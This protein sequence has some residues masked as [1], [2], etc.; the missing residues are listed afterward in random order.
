MS[1]ANIGGKIAE[2]IEKAFFKVF[3]HQPFA[4]KP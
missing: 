1:D 3:L 4:K 2:K